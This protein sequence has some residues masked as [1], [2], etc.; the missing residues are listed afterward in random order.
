[1]GTRRLRRNWG[2][3]FAGFAAGILTF[4]GFDPRGMLLQTA[5]SAIAPYVIAISWILIPVFVFIALSPLIGHARR[6]HGAYRKAG[7]LGAVAVMVA[8]TSGFEL[9]IWW[10]LALALFVTGLLLYGMGR[11]S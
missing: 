3:L 2:P 5:V 7:A 1:M 10:Q 9:A 6:A 11:L 8:F 4:I